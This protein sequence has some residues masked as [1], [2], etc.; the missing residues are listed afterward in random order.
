M[1]TPATWWAWTRLLEM[2]GSKCQFCQVWF[3]ELK[4]YTACTIE[5][6]EKGCSQLLVSSHLFLKSSIVKFVILG[7]SQSEDTF[8][9]ASLVR[10]AFGVF[11]YK[12]L[13]LLE[14]VL[15]DFVLLLPC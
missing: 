12:V 13:Y 7:G 8:L 6:S 10:L 1:S 11:S 14:G 9:I 15:D 3:L 4:F 5:H 2:I